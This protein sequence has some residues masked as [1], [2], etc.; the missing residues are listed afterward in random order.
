MTDSYSPLVKQIKLEVIDKT[1][2]STIVDDWFLEEHLMEVERLANWLCDQ[3]PTAD[4]EVV[5]LAV[6]FHDIGRVVGIDEGHDKYGAQNARERL[7]QAGY[8]KVDLVVEACRSHRAEAIK[9]KSI[10]AKILATADAMSHLVSPKFYLRI[11]DFHRKNMA[12]DD[13]VALMKNKLERDYSQKLFFEQA[14][15]KV[16]PIYQAWKTILYH[17]E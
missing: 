17:K 4:R 5:N 10:E 8:Q 1:A 14:K 11:F 3:Y 2:A 13:V 16:T 6:W 12:F 15:E 7:S 9:P